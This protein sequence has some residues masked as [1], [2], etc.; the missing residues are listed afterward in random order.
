MKDFLIFSPLAILALMTFLWARQLK[1]KNA[2]PV[3]AAWA[4]GIGVQTICLALLSQ[5]DPVRRLVIAGLVGIWAVRLSGHIYFDRIR[6]GQEDGRYTRFRREW[7]P[8]AFYGLYAAQAALV[9]LLPLTFWG[10]LGN[11]SMFPT[12]WDF[13][14]VGIWALSLLGEAAADRQLARF[15][16]HP[17]HRGKTCRQG[18]WKYSRHPNYFFEWLLWCSYIPLSIGSNSFFISLLGPGLLLLLLLKVSGIPPTEAQALESRGD[19]YRDYQRTTSAFL[20]W[21]SKGARS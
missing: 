19:D 14:A 10:A 17:D 8:V 2:T 9:Y 16:A 12:T 20:P 11:I 13:L 18:L 6:S 3:D 4:I 15:R 1:T 21:F 7:S 5:G